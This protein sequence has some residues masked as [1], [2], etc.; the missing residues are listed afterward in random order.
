MAFSCSSFASVSLA[1]QVAFSSS[2]SS[3]HISPSFVCTA[4]RPLRSGLSFVTSGRFSLTKIMKAVCGLFGS[5]F[6]NFILAMVRRFL[7]SYEAMAWAYFLPSG[8]LSKAAASSWCFSIASLA[9]FSRSARSSSG[10]S[11]NVLARSARPLPE[12]AISLQYALKASRGLCGALSGFFGL[13]K[14]RGPLPLALAL[15]FALTLTA[16]LNFIQF[17][18]LLNSSMDF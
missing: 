15:P 14:L 5:S 11:L 13:G 3:F 2:L 17:S 12:P 9:C 7:L 18:L 4:P 10:S 1:V 16:L 8:V 6:R